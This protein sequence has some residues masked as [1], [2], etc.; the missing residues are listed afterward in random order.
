MEKYCPKCEE[1]KLVEEFSPSGKGL[2]PYCKKCYKAIS[3]ERYKA[4]KQSQIDRV[5]AYNKKIYE[6]YKVWKNTLIC[7]CCP[8]NVGVCL[9]FHH[10]N[11]DTKENHP[12]SILSRSGI[13]KFKEELQ[14]CIVVC[15]NC[16]RK[17]HA[18]LID[19]TNIQ[20]VDVKD[21]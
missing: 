10:L 1:T 3:K 6:H 11:P 20:P 5:V 14:Q 8:E 18:G 7:S 2:Q 9:D 17:I 16:H 4:N 15:S 21:L 13:K 12:T 19:V